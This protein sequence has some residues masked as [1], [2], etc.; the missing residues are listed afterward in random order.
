MGHSGDDAVHKIPHKNENVLAEPAE[1]FG[2][3]LSWRSTRVLDTNIWMLY[4]Y[5]A[6][7]IKL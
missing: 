6:H 2:I 7:L 5:N 1:S 4:V 3:G